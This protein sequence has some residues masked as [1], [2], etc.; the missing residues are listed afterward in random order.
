MKLT[1]LFKSKK[2]VITCEVGPVKG[3]C[4]NGQAAPSFLKEALGIKEFVHAV[5]VT[6]NQSA[7][8]RL[9]SLAAS[10]L[11]K[12]AGL[13]PVYQLTCRDRNRIALQSDLLSA[14]S[15]GI[16]NVLCLT[17]DHVKM[18]DHPTAKMVFDV[19]SVHL[20]RIARGL[21]EGHDLMGH[22]LTQPANLALGAVVNPNFQPLDLQLLKMEKK[23]AA[24][25]EFF[26][27]QAVYDPRLFESFIRKTAGFGVPIQYG[28]VIIKS[29]QM[30][31][32]MNEKISGIRVP[33]AIVQEMAKAS[34][35]A[36]KDKAVE[37]TARLVKEIAPMV[38]GIHFMPLGWSDIVPRV[39]DG[40]KL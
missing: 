10:V 19:D 40:L 33:Q 20:L 16:D 31:Q 9:G 34:P 24:G 14:C 6:D 36:Y 21:N 18:G 27:T 35:D 37:I 5:N 13:E 4:R 15:L 17:G 25:A 12:T 3:C 1:G 2:F 23:I 11:L 7:V 28:A 8:M 29:P 39:L 26:Q 30:A 22:Q 32:Y 38:Q